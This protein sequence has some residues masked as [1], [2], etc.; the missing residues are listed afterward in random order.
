MPSADESAPDVHS[1]DYGDADDVEAFL[2]THADAPKPLARFLDGLRGRVLCAWCL[3]PLRA[4][5]DG[6]PLPEATATDW[7]PETVIE[8]Q[9]R[10]AS[11][12]TTCDHADCEH[13]GLVDP[14][15][16]G[17]SRSTEEF[18]RHLDSLLASLAELY[19][20]EF[21]ADVEA[22]HEALQDALADDT[23]IGADS[24]ILAC[25]LADALDVDETR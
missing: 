11:R 13:P 4:S 21:T 9:H 15:P 8:G 22:G 1:V 3:S 5:P 25:G 7:A 24:Y 14:L 20:F 6:P 19:P 23:N 17:E 18:H 16:P 12:R 2:T 10:G